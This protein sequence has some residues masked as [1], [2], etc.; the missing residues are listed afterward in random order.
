MNVELKNIG[1]GY[2]IMES[3]AGVTILFDPIDYLCFTIIFIIYHH[4]LNILIFL[5]YYLELLYYNINS[6]NVSLN[7]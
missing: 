1:L 5:F 3:L 2:Q 7:I 6:N 4:I